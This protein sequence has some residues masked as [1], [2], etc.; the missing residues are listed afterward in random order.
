[1]WFADAPSRACRA[2]C[3]RPLVLYHIVWLRIRPGTDWG[4]EK[5][6]VEFVQD[7]GTLG[8]TVGKGDVEG[9]VPFWCRR[10]WE[11]SQDDAVRSIYRLGGV[12][13]VGSLAFPPTVEI[14]VIV[15]MQHPFSCLSD[16]RGIQCDP[17]SGSSSSPPPLAASLT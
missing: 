16:R 3:W 5:R 7:K 14:A 4:G 12:R 13:R 2:L 9:V 6:Y 11:I 1:M 17:S 8:I 10:P 15:I